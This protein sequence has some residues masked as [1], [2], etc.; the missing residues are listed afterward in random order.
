M[1]LTLLL[2]LIE[3]L[4]QLTA[5]CQ[6]LGHFYFAQIS[7]VVCI[8]PKNQLQN[9]L[10]YILCW[11]C[12]VSEKITLW[13]TNLILLVVTLEDLLLNEKQKIYFVPLTMKK[14]VKEHHFFTL[15]ISL[16]CK[17]RQRKHW[18]NV[19]QLICRSHAKNRTNLSK[20]KGVLNH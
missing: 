7:F 16:K 13:K 19:F 15:V 4:M 12:V 14:N 10:W 1:T 5:L 18:S 20:L 17:N 3:V 6:I 2:L 11:I 8:R 9:I